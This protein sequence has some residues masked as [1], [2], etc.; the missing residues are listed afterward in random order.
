MRLMNTVSINLYPNPTEDYTIAEYV[1]DDQAGFKRL[2]VIDLN[3]RTVLEV[4]VNDT[5]GSVRINTSQLVPG[6]YFLKAMNNGNMVL[7]KKLIIQ[8]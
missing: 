4:P 5:R 2:Y 7:V 6:M 3:G 1:I 8:R